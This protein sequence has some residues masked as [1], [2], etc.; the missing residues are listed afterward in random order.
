MT[1]PLGTRT[2][3]GGG[4]G[5]DKTGAELSKKNRAR[6]DRCRKA[7]KAC[8]DDLDD[9]LAK[10]A[11]ADEDDKGA[12]EADTTAETKTETETK[13]DT[14]QDA[15]EASGQIV[16][17][18]LAEGTPGAEPGAK[19]KT[20]EGKPVVIDLE[21]ADPA[22]WRIPDSWIQLPAKVAAGDD[23]E[24]QEYLSGYAAVKHLLE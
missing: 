23:K 22:E 19:G 2:D 3:D 13:T 18:E 1:I 10:W 21:L 9:L 8:H 20:D 7:L 16:I 24:R 5:I 17:E 4:L 15:P 12:G 11:D 14:S 6:L